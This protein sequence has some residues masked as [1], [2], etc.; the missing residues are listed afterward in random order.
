MGGW[1]TA[2]L[3]ERDRHFK[4]WKKK[5]REGGPSTFKMINIHLGSVEFSLLGSRWMGELGQKSK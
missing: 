4:G 1:E 3:R 2:K 5:K